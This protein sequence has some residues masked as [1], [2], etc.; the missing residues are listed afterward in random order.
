VAMARKI[1]RF[2][3]QAGVPQDPNERLR[4]G[5]QAA[6]GAADRFAG[7]EVGMV[8]LAP[9][10]DVIKVRYGFQ[11]LELISQGQN[12]AI[13]GQINPVAIAGTRVIKPKERKDGIR[14]ETGQSITI[15]S[16]AKIIILEFKR[17]TDERNVN[18]NEMTEALQHHQDALNNL[19]VAKWLQNIDSFDANKKAIENARARGRRSLMKEFTLK[20]AS[21]WKNKNITKEQLKKLVKM[22]TIALD[23]SHAADAVAGG[24][25]DEFDSLERNAI[26][27]YF[28]TVWGKFK[29]DL[30][31][32]AEEIRKQF[33]TKE[34][35]ENVNMNFRL[36]IKFKN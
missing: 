36:R 30:K 33:V 4:L 8:V 9:L 28:G 31:S 27:Q 18:I 3:A 25:I 15:I 26:N 29:E 17:F 10:L 19:K 1:G 11:T 7:R 14:V 20:L 13:R 32:Y 22:K 21:E 16:P 6:V 35:R 24:N 23:A 12:W 5:I 2:V 34:Q